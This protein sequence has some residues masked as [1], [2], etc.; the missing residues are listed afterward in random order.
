MTN[1]Q[2]REINAMVHVMNEIVDEAIGNV[3]PVRES[4]A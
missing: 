1:D 2:V 4:E 3:L